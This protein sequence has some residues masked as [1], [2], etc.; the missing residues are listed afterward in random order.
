MLLSEPNAFISNLFWEPISI[1]CTEIV[2][3]LNAEFKSAKQKKE[4]SNSRSSIFNDSRKII[5]SK[6]IG[7]NS[8]EK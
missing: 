7:K 3:I 8:L 6:N 5:Y 4:Y 1:W 2:K